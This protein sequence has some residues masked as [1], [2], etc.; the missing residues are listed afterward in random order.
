M[1]NLTELEVRCEDWRIIMVFRVTL[2][3]YIISLVNW[4]C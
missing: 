2:F 4:D 3:G 1:V